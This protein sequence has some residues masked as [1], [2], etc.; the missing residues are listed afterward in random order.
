MDAPDG[1]GAIKLPD[2]RM[3]AVELSEPPLPLPNLFSAR[4][5]GL[6]SDLLSF[7][8]RRPRRF[9]RWSSPCWCMW[10]SG[11]TILVFTRHLLPR[12]RVRCHCFMR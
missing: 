6:V 1:L 12:F 4:G 3:K 5:E 7:S 11:C 2:T 9:E 8:G 10:R